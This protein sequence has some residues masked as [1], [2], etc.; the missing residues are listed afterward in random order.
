MAKRN[1]KKDKYKVSILIPCYNEEKNVSRCIRSCLSQT[2]KPDQIV[3]VDDCSTDKTPQKLAYFGRKIKVVRTPKNTRNKSH[4]QE[5]GLQFIKGDIVVTTDADTVLDKNFVKEVVADF[6]DKK[7]AA[8][9]GYVR[10]MKYNWIT[11]CR[12]LDYIVGQ[13]IHK[14]AQ[15]YLGFLFVIP[16]AAGAFRTEAFRKYL[17]FDHDTLTEDLDFTYKLHEM[18]KKIVYNRNAIVYTQDPS[19]LYSYINQMRR[20]FGGGWQNLAKHYKSALVPS[21]AIEL[22]LM[23]V[24]GIVYSFLL[25]LLPII[26]IRFSFTLLTYYFAAAVV[27]AIYA[28]LKEK[29]YDILLTPLPYLFLMY[30]NAYVFL[31]QFFSVVVMGKRNLVWFQPERVKI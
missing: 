25:F 16:G 7:V 10:S 3:A 8:V 2:R 23:Y 4:A 17:S 22:S 13:N 1:T 30:I 18:G 31:E 27:F 26:N 5:Y 21:R 29:R 28:A 11:A 9:G 20:W 6:E 12:A 14:L 19:S 24:E 15:S